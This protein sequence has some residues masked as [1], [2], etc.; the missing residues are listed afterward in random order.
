MR[1][2][3]PSFVCRA[4]DQCFSALIEPAISGLAHAAHRLLGAMLAKFD[5]AR[6]FRRTGDHVSIE[7]GKR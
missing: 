7:L 3:D 2:I 4:L 1:R 5:R 6:H